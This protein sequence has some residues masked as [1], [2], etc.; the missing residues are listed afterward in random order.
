MTMTVYFK[1]GTTTILGIDYCSIVY[2]DKRVVKAIN[3][4]TKEVIF[5]KSQG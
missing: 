3:N 4:K 2:K 1:D 5:D